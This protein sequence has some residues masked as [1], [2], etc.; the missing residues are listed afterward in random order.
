MTSMRWY[1][2]VVFCFFFLWLPL[3]HIDAAY[4]IRAV[5]EAYATATATPNLS[6]IWDLCLSLW[7]CQIFNTEQG[8]GSILHPHMDS[9]GFLT[10]WDTIGTLIVVL[11]F[12]SLIIG[13]VEPLFL[14]L[15]TLCISFFRKMSISSALLCVYLFLFLLFV[16]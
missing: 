16:F 2:I 8:Q 10:H 3:Q 14:C 12:I 5:A 1:L 4:Q 15:F 13:D 6:C 11:I 9:I 7:Q